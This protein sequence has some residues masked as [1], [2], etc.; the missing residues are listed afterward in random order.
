M[1]IFQEVRGFSESFSDFVEGGGTRL[2]RNGS[3][4]T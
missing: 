2:S 1:L 4:R 3:K